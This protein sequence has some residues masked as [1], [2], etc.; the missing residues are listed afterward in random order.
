MLLNCTNHPHETWT[1]A[2]RDAAARQFGEVADHPFPQVQPTWDVGR[3]RREVGSYADGIEALAPDAV[4]AAGEFTF[5]FMLV[6]RLLADGV[7][8]VCSCSVRNTV[9][10]KDEAGNNVKTS[11]FAFEGFRPYARWREGGATA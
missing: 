11:V 5:L 6:D 1:D 7:E 8:V 9:E 2:Q 10:T 4:L 3:L